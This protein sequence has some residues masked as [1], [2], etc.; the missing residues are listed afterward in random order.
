MQNEQILATVATIAVLALL[1][2]IIINQQQKGR[3]NWLKLGAILLLAATF[4][5]TLL[6]FD[7]Y[8]AETLLL[9]KT[10]QSDISSH[11]T[12]IIGRQPS[13]DIPQLNSLNSTLTPPFFSINI[14]SITPTGYFKR[15]QSDNPQP[16]RQQLVSQT[17]TTRI[18]IKR[19]TRH[20]DIMRHPDNPDD[21]LQLYHLTTTSGEQLLAILTP[22]DAHPGQ[23]P[24]GT[25][26][27]LDGKLKQIAAADTTLNQ[28]IYLT[29][30][31]SAHYTH[32][33]TTLLAITAIAALLATALTAAIA[34]AI[35]L[36][37]K[38]HHKQ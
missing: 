25:A 26:I 27:P 31:D 23:S 2:R 38:K 20:F 8:R 21:Y 28:N 12:H 16:I 18:A 22:Y 33:Q 34:R 4:I 11:N 7:A 6:T 32:A 15:K 29:F 35:Y 9:G 1:A 10:S 19:T 14:N 3:V 13:N 30:F 36:L 24:V 5:S 17:D 37:I